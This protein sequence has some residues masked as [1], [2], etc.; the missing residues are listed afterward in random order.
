MTL[1]PPMAMVL[2]ILQVLGAAI[3][4]TAAIA[5]ELSSVSLK[6]DITIVALSGDVAQGDTEAAEALIK[7]ANDGNRLISAV[8][9][10]SPGGSLAEAIKLAGLIRRAKLPTIV[11]AGSRCASA[12]FIVFAAGNEKFASYEAAIG[13][14]GVSDKFGHETAQTEE[15]TIAM[16]R[17]ASGFGV[18]PR[19]IGQMV[20]THAHEIAWLTPDDLR[21]MGAI[22]TD[23][24]RRHAP[25]P[26]SPD[27]RW[28]A[29]LGNQPEDAATRSQAA[30]QPAH[31]AAGRSGQ[32]VLPR[33]GR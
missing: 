33:Q 10:D 32:H 1:R 30:D 3:F 11:A 23:R 24:P 2:S 15:A 8:R 18:P 16:A 17:V 27:D 29:G 5:A 12:C 7:A 26:T 20:A 21:A 25:P 28:L 13:V 31:E 22:M 9:L 6:G 14:H 4:S 19:I